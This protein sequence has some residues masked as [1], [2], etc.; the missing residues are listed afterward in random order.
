MKSLASVEVMSEIRGR[1]RSVRVDD[2]ARWGKMTAKRMVRHLICSYAVALGER[3][4]DPLQW[5]LLV[6]M[7]W[8]ALRSGLR[9]P[10]NIQ[11][12]PELKRAIA[13]HS[14]VEF[15]V[16]IRAVVESMEAVAK[17][18]HHAPSHPMFGPMTPEDWMRWGYLHADHHLRQFGR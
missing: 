18:P 10:K 8:M 1:L 7:K 14:E 2:R 6:L 11:T 16:L 12:V 17:G 5:P 4:V 9:W 13:E 3:T 15:N